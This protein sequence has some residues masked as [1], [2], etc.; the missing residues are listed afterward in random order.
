MVTKK[1]A[2]SARQQE[3]DDIS[4]EAHASSN[5]Q[6]I[7]LCHMSNVYLADQKLIGQSRRMVSCR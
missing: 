1:R 6:P 5:D 2:H 4:F 3:D 7:I